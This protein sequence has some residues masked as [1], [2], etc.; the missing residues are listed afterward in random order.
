MVNAREMDCADS[1][2]GVLSG[3]A[4]PE[5]PEISIVDLGIVR[6]V[7]NARGGWRITV[8]PTYS[9]CPAFDV[10][11]GDI[12]SAL[13]RAGYAP[14]EVVRALSPPWSSDWLS[15]KAKK[16]LLRLGISPPGPASEIKPVLFFNLPSPPCPRCGSPQT[17]TTGQF[18][19]TACKS[20][21]RCLSCREPFEH[22]KPI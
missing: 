8:T 13:N 4:D 2:R 21:H 20:L 1:V 3:V 5:I 12:V 7:E 14:V 22:F 19:A 9:G 16:T 17:E 10:I 6:K 18:G 15:G 11:C